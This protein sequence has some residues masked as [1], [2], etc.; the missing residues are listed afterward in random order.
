LSAKTSEER[1]RNASGVRAVNETAGMGITSESRCHRYPI[2]E[3]E[4][5]F[6]H[7]VAAEF[8]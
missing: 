6:F 2:G 1:W 8:R 5:M 4:D 3:R 7:P